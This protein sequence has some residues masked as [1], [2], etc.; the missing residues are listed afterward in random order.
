MNPKPDIDRLQSWFEIYV[1]GFA[2]DDPRIQENMDLKAAHTRRVRAAILDI[3]ASLKLPTA[4]LCMAEA[5][6]WLHDIG[7]FEQYTRYGTFMDHRSEDHAA[8]GVKVI[9]KSGVLDQL[10][11]LDS[12]MIKRVVGS[13]NRAE[14]PHG[15]DERTL[16]F[17]RLLRDADKIDIWRVVAT[18][19]QHSNGHRNAAIEL[20]LPDLPEI[21]PP[22]YETLMNGSLVRMADLRTLNDFK[23]LQMGWIYDVNFPRTFQIVREKGYLEAIRDALSCMSTRTSDVYSRA[24]SYLDR[25]CSESQAHGRGS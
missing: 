7:R 17:L 24:R 14:L 3:G 2:S 21:S 11:H 9:E 22:V 19:Y 5:T 15:E 16:F 1:S 4:D 18:Y 10:K 12:H 8:L 25:H 6:A 20:N 13:H 23:L